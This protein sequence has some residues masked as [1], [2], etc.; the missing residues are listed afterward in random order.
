MRQLSYNQLLDAYED[1]VFYELD[2]NFIMM[3]NE[4]INRR[5]LEKAESRIISTS[6]FK[7]SNT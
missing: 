4:E 6:V 7:A 1:A 5:D 3:L 2:Q